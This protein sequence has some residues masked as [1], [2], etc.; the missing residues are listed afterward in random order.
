MLPLVHLQRLGECE[1][2]CAHLARE[3]TLASVSALVLSKRALSRVGLITVL[4]CKTLDRHMRS[5]MNYEVI[6]HSKAAGALVTHVR[7]GIRVHSL[8]M[9]A[10]I[11]HFGKHF[12]AH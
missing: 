1:R 6:A 3:G 10:Q 8:F 5:H 4:A 2:F 9:L 7:P 11:V 12:V